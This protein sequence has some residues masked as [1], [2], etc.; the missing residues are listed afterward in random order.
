MISKA[1]P[2][3]LVLLRDLAYLVA[4]IT[5][6]SHKEHQDTHRTHSTA[7][8]KHLTVWNF[9]SRAIIWTCRRDRLKSSFETWVAFS[10]C[11]S[12]VTGRGRVSG[13]LNPCIITNSLLK[14]SSQIFF[15]R[16]SCVSI[17]LPSIPHAITILLAQRTH[18]RLNVIRSSTE[19]GRLAFWREKISWSLYKYCESNRNLNCY[20]VERINGDI[21]LFWKL[22][23]SW[24]WEESS[25]QKYSF[26]FP[27][28]S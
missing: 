16:H 21:F 2:A 9:R 1:K 23:K 22:G 28:F 25:K 4:Q 8:K 6:S 27:S 19:R 24:W 5:A 12:W 15:N 10:L 18:R 20:V 14:P 7:T 17:P 26:Q 3:R 11:L 13:V